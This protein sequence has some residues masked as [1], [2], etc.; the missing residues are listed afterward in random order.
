MEASRQT[1]HPDWNILQL[2]ITLL[3]NVGIIRLKLNEIEATIKSVLLK[4]EKQ[5][6]NEEF[7]CYKIFGKLDL[8]EFQK[9]IKKI[10]ESDNLANEIVIFEDLL[11]PIVN[12][13]REIHHT[14]LASV[15]QPIENDFK[16]L[17]INESLTGPDLPDFSF[18]PMEYITLIGQ[19]LLTLPQHLEPLLLNPS[20][21]LKLALELSEPNYKDNI[22]PADILSSLVADECCVAFY[23][24][25]RKIPAINSNGAKQLATDIEYLG[26]ILEELGLTMSSNL[27]QTATLLK[28][29]SDSKGFMAAAS[30]VDA[31]LIRL[32]RI[33]RQ[34]NIAD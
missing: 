28:A 26:S 9:I 15:F 27:Q 20:V 32:I 11:E 10:N 1:D 5:M 3:E 24:K 22:P 19:Y 14:T 31:R 13:G 16:K 17:E 4:K 8:N 12:I 30:G 33:I 6:Q 29:P 23:E 34:I 25:I 2:A 21:P 7:F 18:T